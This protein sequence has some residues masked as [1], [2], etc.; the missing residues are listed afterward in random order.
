MDALG[1][2]ELGLKLV[3][4]HWTFRIRMMFYVDGKIFL[5]FG[6]FIQGLIGLSRLGRWPQQED[7]PSDKASAH[8]MRRWKN[9]G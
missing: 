6:L 9:S 4:N 3:K 8:R 7:E 5:D 1:L 2:T